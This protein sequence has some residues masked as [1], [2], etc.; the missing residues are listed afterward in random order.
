MF[1]C[2]CMYVHFH[3]CVDAL[4]Q[5]CVCVQN[6]RLTLGIFSIC[7]S[8]LFFV[9]DCLSHLELADVASV[10]SQLPLGSWSQG[11]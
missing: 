8:I 4:V 5:A 11:L 2:V 1:M 3:G 10:L 9:G 7:S 6:L